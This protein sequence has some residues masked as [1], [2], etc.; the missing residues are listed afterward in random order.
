ME[1]ERRGL[2]EH[3]KNIELESHGLRNRLAQDRQDIERLTKE[4]AGLGVKKQ[5]KIEEKRAAI[6]EIADLENSLNSFQIELDRQKARRLELENARDIVREEHNGKLFEIE[7][8]RKGL[9]VDQ[10]DLDAIASKAHAG[11]LDQTRDEQECRRIR[12]RIWEAYEIDFNSPPP[13]MPVI[14]EDEESVMQNIA[15]LK[16]RIKHVGQVNMAAIEDYESESTRLKDLTAQRDDLQKAVEDL[17]LAIKKL[18]KEARV[19]F[20]ATFEQ[21]QKHFTEMFTTLFEG[22]EA[23]IS[24]EENIDPLEAPIHINV[25]PNGKKMRGVQLLSGGERALTAISLLFALYLVK[26][27]AYCILDELDA[28]LDDANIGRFVRV[29]RKFAEQTQFI[30][31]THNKR[32]MEAADLLYGVTQQESGVSSIVSVKFQEAQLQAA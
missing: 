24:L 9:K 18:D 12:E 30:V 31:I 17:E 4:I 22:G 13:D 3:L 8:V 16:E 29:L 20:I 11:E 28:P 5:D 1:D 21:V 15:M 27:S 7:E 19:Q 14:D 2:S 25:R 6:S 32:T 26:P 10:V 23:N